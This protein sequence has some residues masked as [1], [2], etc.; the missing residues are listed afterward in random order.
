MRALVAGSGT[1]GG[2]VPGGIVGELLRSVLA[3]VLVASTRVVCDR[4]GTRTHK[5]SVCSPQAT[6]RRERDE[7]GRPV[8]AGHPAE[9]PP[10]PAR[11]GQETRTNSRPFQCHRTVMGIDGPLAWESSGA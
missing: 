5:P 2:P 9:R 7:F 8:T 3:E 4:P 10:R 1:A 11:L 6:V